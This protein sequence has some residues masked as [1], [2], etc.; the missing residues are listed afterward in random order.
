MPGAIQ[1]IERAAAALRL[2]ARS[3]RP[4]ALAELAATLD[5]PRPTLHGIL[6]TLREVGFVDQDPATAQYRVGAGL[7]ELGTQRWD[8]HDLRSRTMNWADALAGSTG[9]AVFVGVPDG[10]A[11]SVVHHVFRPDDS[12]QRLRTNETVPL[13]ATALGKCLLAFAPLVT[14]PARD[15]ELHR[16]TGRT[17]TSLADL[18]SHLGL[19]RRRGAATCFG[20]YTAGAGGAAVP[21]RGG[22]GVAVGVLG[23]S[24]PVE[25]L[26]DT[27]GVPRPR[28]VAELTAAGREISETLGHP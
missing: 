19:A 13:H 17:C 1:S 14:P 20:E 18:Q 12:P 4:L 25:Q 8:R 22:G 16:Y 9:C 5:L 3:G 28:L 11:V 2:L 27:G 10:T 15:L 21:L 23:I 6:R 24:G 7:G 26:F